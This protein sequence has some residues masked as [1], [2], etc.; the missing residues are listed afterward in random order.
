MSKFKVIETPI[1]GLLVVEPTT[2]SDKNGFVIDVDSKKDLIEIG[3]DFEFVQEKSVKEVRRGTLRGLNFQREQTQGRLI[4]VVSG[5]VVDVAVDLRPASKTYGGWYSTGLSAENQRMLWVPEQFANGFLTI[6]NNTEVVFKSTDY[7]KQEAES[8]IMWND[9]TVNI[10]WPFD[11]YEIDEKYMI[12]S[13]RDKKLPSYGSWHPN[14]IWDKCGR[15]MKI[16]KNKNLSKFL[17]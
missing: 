15:R 14:E 12:V 16:G 7:D 5:A 8:G 17:S 3:I 6:E 2:D 10:D 4:R 11:R 13:P 1:K 9:P